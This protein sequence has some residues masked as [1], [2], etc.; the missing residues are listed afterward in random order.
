MAD[1][2]KGSTVLVEEMVLLMDLEVEKEIYIYVMAL[3]GPAL[4]PLGKLHTPQ[5][6]IPSFTK[7]HSL[8]PISRERERS[9]CISVVILK[10]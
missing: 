10:D 9:M 3:P 5:D 6:L 2:I 8:I 7:P 1:A 4:S